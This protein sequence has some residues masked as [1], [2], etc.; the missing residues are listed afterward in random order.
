[1]LCFLFFSTI[2]LSIDGLAA[3]IILGLQRLKIAIS[4]RIWIALFLAAL[5]HFPSL[6]EI[7]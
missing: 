4:A 1:M 2:A 5:Q 7:I 3:G 6:L